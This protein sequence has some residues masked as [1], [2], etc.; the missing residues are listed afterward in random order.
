M[1]YTGFQAIKSYQRLINVESTK[2]AVCRTSKSAT[3]IPSAANPADAPSRGIPF[4]QLSNLWWRGPDFL[5]S[6]D[7]WPVMPDL[8]QL[9]EEE[10]PIN[11]PLVSNTENA[12]LQTYP[13][14]VSSTAAFASLIKISSI[15]IWFLQQF[16]TCKRR[17][18]FDAKH[19]PVTWA[20]LLWARHE[21]NCHLNDLYDALKQKK[22]HPL[23]NEL[24][25]SLDEL[26]IIRCNGGFKHALLSEFEKSPIYV[27]TTYE[28]IRS[29][30]FHDT[31]LSLKILERRHELSTSNRYIGRR[32]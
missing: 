20:Q 13:F 12:C 16:A 11:T 8:K 24:G 7:D 2:S 25:L 19:D 28:E 5:S 29:G 31:A 32:Q 9:Y 4:D 27:L 6:H 15:C 22:P 3:Y 30:P 14:D 23:I 17:Q 1:F 10:I 21:Q 26:D 18:L